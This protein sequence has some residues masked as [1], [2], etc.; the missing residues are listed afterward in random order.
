MEKYQYP[1]T[2]D[3]QFPPLEDIINSFKKADV[4][5]IKY[6]DVR[7]L[8][9]LLNRLKMISARV[10]GHIQKRRA[11]LMST[12][13]DITSYDP[14]LTNDI[15]SVRNRLKKT[16]NT[17]IEHFIDYCI[18]GKFVLKLRWETQTQTLPIKASFWKPVEFIHPEPWDTEAN[19]DYT[20]NVCLLL[21]EK[22]RFTR[23]EL[24]ETVEESWLSSTFEPNNMGGI[25]RNI[26]ILEWLLYMDIQDWRNFNRRLKGLLL[27][28]YKDFGAAGVGAQEKAEKAIA[29]AGTINWAAV[30]DNIKFEFLKIVDSVG[31]SS[32]P[33]FKKA[34][35]SDIA[36][37]IRG[38][39]NTTE[40]PNQGGSRA[41][42]E[43][44]IFGVEEDIAFLDRMECA[45]V[46]N[47]Q[48][49]KQ[50]YLRNY[51]AMGEDNPDIPWEFVFNV[52]YSDDKEQ[53][54]RIAEIL[55]RNNI[56]LYT[57]EIAQ[58]TGFTPATDVEII[59]PKQG[60]LG[61]GF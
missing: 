24:I 56:P 32:F 5:N 6:R 52:K 54:T 26:L 2:I 37:A 30:P 15:E 53:N 14:N 18:F 58:Q 47:E 13:W 21:H 10:P 46:I 42:L 19:I 57:K 60:G 7:P 33:D 55:L 29:Q 11:T 31:A 59:Q 8:M 1:Y 3:T 61:F 22:S 35:E 40:L 50:D 43:A 27:A 12:V 20:N 38:T 4:K 25:L 23:Q 34:I 39:A 48:L 36:I 16:I 9:A 44:L 17:T 45:K 28:E 49:F 51:S 41:A